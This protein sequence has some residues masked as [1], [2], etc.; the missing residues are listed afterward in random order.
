MSSFS[1]AP[2]GIKGK[3]FVAPNATACQSMSFSAIDMPSV[4]F[5]VQGNFP[6]VN[7]VS[8]T[9]PYVIG[10]KILQSI[11]PP[12]TCNRVNRTWPNFVKD[13]ATGLY[14]VEDR[15]VQLYDNTNATTTVKKRLL[16]GRCPQAEKS[17]L[18]ADTCVVRTDCAAPAFSGQFEL[19]A[20]NLRKFYEIG[21]KYQNLP[22]LDTP[23]P[24]SKNSNRFVRKNAAGDSSGCAADTSS[25]FP[26]I[27]SALET[28]LNTAVPA[29]DRG[30]KRVIDLP[31]TPWNVAQHCTDSNSAATGK[32]F[33]VTMPGGGL[34]CW[35]HAYPFEWSVLV[36][37]DWVLNHPGNPKYFSESRVNPIA[38]PA[39]SE[40][41]V[42][43][44]ESSVTL[45]YPPWDFH[46]GNFHDNRWRF[47]SERIGS[48]GDK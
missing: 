32:S 24:C 5:H 21:G 15:R 19:N 27:R 44:L 46:K 4:H 28:F 48:W 7:L 41:S 1:E 11:I 14:F 13:H 29:G 34:S 35:T 8:L 30:A 45:S 40:I 6:A 47:E 10:D 2:G 36:M 39:E 12:S 26:T 42:A 25:S 22:V 3:L 43:D 37:N 31:E 17:F 20:T 16:D 18:N 33:T 23:S 38:A 9:D